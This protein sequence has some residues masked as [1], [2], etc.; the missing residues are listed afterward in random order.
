[1]L[2]R[3]ENEES[4]S[5]K[6]KLANFEIYKVLFGFAFWGCSTFLII[7]KH[8]IQIAGYFES[9]HKNHQGSSN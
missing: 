7:K 6:S 9:D 3:R 5:K 1:M 2:K 8:L 4:S